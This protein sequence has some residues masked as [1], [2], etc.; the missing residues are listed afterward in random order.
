LAYLS[1]NIY[2]I[3]LKDLLFQPYIQILCYPKPTI[4]EAENRIKEL[5][6]LNVFKI[7]FFG[8]KE[9]SG[10]KILGKGCVGIVIKAYF[11]NK[12][13]A[14]KIRRVDANRDSLIYEAFML[15]KVNE[16][17]IGPKLYNYTKNFLLMEFINGQSIVEWIKQLTNK[18]KLKSVLIKILEDCFKLDEIGLDH[19]ELSRANKHILI[20]NS[21]TP[22]IIDFETASE[23]RYASNITKICNF[24]F[25]KGEI[26]LKIN[27]VLNV[28]LNELYNALKIYKKNKTRENFEKILKLCNLKA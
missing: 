26:A 5:Q 2:S 20:N 14:L 10:L 17:G 12:P 16:Y 18:E 6:N 21:D 11:N 23:K 15:K 9:V 27:E 13:A 22:I 25:F 3:T 19:G 7:E 4:E 28:S 1:K 8:K 24:L